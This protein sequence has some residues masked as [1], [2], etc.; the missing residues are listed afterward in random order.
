MRPSESFLVN[1][2]LVVATSTSTF[3]KFGSRIAAINYCNGF[4]QCDCATF[5]DVL[6][7]SSGLEFNV[8]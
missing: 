3:L 2:N 6:A 1:K 7:S 5:R 4:S 8:H